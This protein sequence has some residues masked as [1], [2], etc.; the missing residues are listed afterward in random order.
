MS[1]RPWGLGR[2]AVFDQG[3]LCVP[4]EVKEVFISGC[5]APKAMERKDLLVY[6]W[7]GARL[8]APCVFVI[9]EGETCYWV[10]VVTSRLVGAQILCSNQTAVASD[11]Y[12]I[13]ETR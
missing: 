4:A 1:D 11:L 6:E 5:P 13:A 10:V 3:L 12:R 7:H 9:C 2:R 8:A